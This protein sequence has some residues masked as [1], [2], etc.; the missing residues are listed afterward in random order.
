VLFVRQTMLSSP[1]EQ[2]KESAILTNQ[3]FSATTRECDVEKTDI[4]C[5]TNNKDVLLFLSTMVCVT[6]IYKRKDK[7]YKSNQMLSSPYKEGRKRR[8]VYPGITTVFLFCIMVSTSVIGV[9]SAF[10]P[11][12]T[13]PT[14]IMMKPLLPIYYRNRCRSNAIFMVHNDKGKDDEDDDNTVN[15]FGFAIGQIAILKTEKLDQIK[16]NGKKMIENA[17]ITK[18]IAT[19]PIETF[20]QIKKTRKQNC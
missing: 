12:S 10:Q 14:T 6:D 5:L 1:L 15:R 2:L 4:D 18:E 11:T 19:P 3:I 20:H 8:T 9:S 7:E 17:N 13:L 16:K